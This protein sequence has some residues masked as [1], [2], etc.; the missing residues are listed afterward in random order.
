M[1]FTY[2]TI[3]SVLV[4]FVNAVVNH[5]KGHH[6]VRGE[7]SAITKKMLEMAT[8]DLLRSRSF[9]DQQMV[10]LLRWTLRDNEYVISNT[11]GLVAW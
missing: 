10:P 8:Q 1:E 7:H 11:I 9:L 5:H 6:A 2:R 3:L 4:A